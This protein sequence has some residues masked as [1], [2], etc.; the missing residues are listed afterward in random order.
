MES[1]VKNI[2]NKKGPA[3]KEKRSFA[4]YQTMLSPSWYFKKIVKS[5]L[6]LEEKWHLEPEKTQ[7]Q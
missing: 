5:K 2:K 7:E 1:W 4:G 3:K 6:N